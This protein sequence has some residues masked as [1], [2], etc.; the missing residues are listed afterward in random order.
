MRTSADS[1]LHKS[2]L[3]K[4]LSFCCDRYWMNTDYSEWEGDSNEQTSTT[5]SKIHSSFKE[6]PTSPIYDQTSSSNCSARWTQHSPRIARQHSPHHRSQTFGSR[7]LQDVCCLSEGLYQDGEPS[8]GTSS[9]FSSHSS[10]SLHA[11]RSRLRWT[12]DLEARKPQKTQLHQS[13]RHQL[14]RNTER[15]TCYLP[16]VAI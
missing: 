13:L 12:T 16:P 10:T 5:P 8:Y 15:T 6:R 1:S 3:T 11:Y 7:N 2:C 14:C 4:A 9:T